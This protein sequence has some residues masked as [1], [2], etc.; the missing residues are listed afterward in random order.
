MVF[1]TSERRV[2]SSV[3]MPYWQRGQHCCQWLCSASRFSR[4][5][6][7]PLGVPKN[8]ALLCLFVVGSSFCTFQ[9]VRMMSGTFLATES[10]KHQE[11]WQ[12]AA[13]DLPTVTH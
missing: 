6:Q 2:M 7:A 8:H 5:V 13:L 1:A 3:S 10:K 9:C 4:F 12:T 11:P